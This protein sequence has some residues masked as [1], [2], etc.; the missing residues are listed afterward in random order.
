MMHGYEKSDSD[1]ITRARAR[2]PG[3]EDYPPPWRRTTWRNQSRD[4]TVVAF[5]RGPFGNYMPSATTTKERDLVDFL[6]MS[7][8][9]F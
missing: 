5:L 8:T 3:A 2:T 6:R 9:S 4:V 7:L 1:S